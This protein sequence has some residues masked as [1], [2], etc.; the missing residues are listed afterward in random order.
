MY[1]NTGFVR[2]STPN[3]A[4]PSLPVNIKGPIDQKQINPL[5]LLLTFFLF[6]ITFPS[7]SCCSFF[8]STASEDVLGGLLILEQ[9]KVHL[10]LRVPPGQAFDDFF[11]GLA[12]ETSRT[13]HHTGLTGL[14]KGVARSPPLHAAHSRL[15]CVSPKFAPTHPSIP[16]L[17]HFVCYMCFG[18]SLASEYSC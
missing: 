14:C 8:V 2:V 4:R 10:P 12:G 9:P 5:F 17:Y 3:R 11:A 6:A 7:P 13:G 18:N 1:F 16:Y 15:S